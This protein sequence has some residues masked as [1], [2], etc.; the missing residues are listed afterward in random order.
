MSHKYNTGANE[1]R[2]LITNG[3]KV[4]S[5]GCTNQPVSDPD[6]LLMQV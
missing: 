6:L 1:E 5:T 2:K 3:T 4:K